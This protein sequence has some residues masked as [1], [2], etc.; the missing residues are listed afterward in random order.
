[1]RLPFSLPAQPAP[2]ESRLVAMNKPGAPLQ[3]ALSRH[4]GPRLDGEGVIAVRG[5]RQRGARVRA[6][7][8][9]DTRE[10]SRA[11]IVRDAVRNRARKRR[12]RGLSGIVPQGG[13][14]PVGAIVD[15]NPD[16]PADSDPS[17][18][19]GMSQHDADKAGERLTV[20]GADQTCAVAVADSSRP[21]LEWNGE[22]GVRPPE[23]RLDAAQIV[24]DTA[25]VTPEL[26][27]VGHLDRGER[28]RVVVVHAPGFPTHPTPAFTARS[29]QDRPMLH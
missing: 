8:P 10:T 2:A 5:E 9:D 20:L 15:L 24:L 14:P 17:S 19:I 11:R 7:E 3:R 23:R 12:L 18:T 28:R 6:G 4:A 25:L 21:R 13:D 16:A 26:R 22:V 1:M 27:H 29:R